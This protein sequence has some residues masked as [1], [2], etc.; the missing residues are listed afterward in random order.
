MIQRH[1]EV[2]IKCNKLIEEV[3]QA[4]G[5]GMLP[6]WPEPDPMGQSIQNRRPLKYTPVPPHKCFNK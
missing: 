5:I 3:M 1:E 6:Q 4:V 2:F